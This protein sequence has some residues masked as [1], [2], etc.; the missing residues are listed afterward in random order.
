VSV[1]LA[2]V[3]DDRG[4]AAARSAVSQQQRSG[5]AGAVDSSGTNRSVVSDH[6]KRRRTLQSSNQRV[7]GEQGDNGTGGVEWRVTRV[8]GGDREAE[9]SGGRLKRR[10]RGSSAVAA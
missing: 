5:G 9:R 7:R 4:C 1:D 10:H 2:F 6:T 3:V 8:V